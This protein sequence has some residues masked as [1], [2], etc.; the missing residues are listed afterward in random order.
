VGVDT[1]AS[2]TS[3]K[4]EMEGAVL[5]TILPDIKP[6]RFHMSRAS[7]YNPVEFGKGRKRSATNSLTFMERK[8]RKLPLSGKGVEE[9]NHI[10]AIK[11]DPG[12]IE[13]P[14]P[15]KKPGISSRSR[16]TAGNAPVTPK[17][18][19][20]P[21]AVKSPQTVRLPNGN[22]MHWDVNSELLAAEMQAY[23]LQEIGRN[24]EEANKFQF[25]HD[26]QT[27][28]PLRKATPSRF[29]PK[30]PALRYAERHPGEAAN[31][32][33]PD[34]MDVDDW[35]SDND[36]IGDESEYIIDTYVRMPANILQTSGSPKN[37]GLLVL[38]SQP[39]I[40]VFYLEEHDSEEEDENE[41]EDENGKSESEDENTSTNDR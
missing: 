23:T 38:E 33:E 7:I 37:F 28:S 20:A 5:Q 25:G 22:F 3:P 19:P 30:K 16:G 26:T 41:D 21:N 2:A 4:P 14:Q 9:N 8:A 1:G 11:L 13:T 27:S 12:I 34:T 24:I 35:S 29:K 18:P 17:P 40:D 6:R 32:T 31:L 10:G 36:D 15:R 39:D